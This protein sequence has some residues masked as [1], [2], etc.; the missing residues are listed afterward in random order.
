MERIL[1]RVKE[2]ITV[3][4][5]KEGTQKLMSRLLLNSAKAV[6]KLEMSKE[7]SILIIF[8]FYQIMTAA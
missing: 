2:L 7:T 3:I 1:L 8:C 5:S 6:S 4:F